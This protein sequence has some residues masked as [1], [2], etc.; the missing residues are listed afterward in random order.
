M[1]IIIYFLNGH[2]IKFNTN[3]NINIIDEITTKIKENVGNNILYK[4]E[5]V[6]SNEY[7]VYIKGTI[8][9]NCKKCL[10]KYKLIDN[11]NIIYEYIEIPWFYEL[12]YSIIEKIKKISQIIYNYNSEKIKRISQIIYNYNSEKIK[13][14]S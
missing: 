6:S 3:N 13:R 9:S 14:I 7:Q 5:K 1:K 4:L 8:Y 2:T 12:F 11:N 10:I